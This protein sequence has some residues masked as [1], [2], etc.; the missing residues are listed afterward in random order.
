MVRYWVGSRVSGKPRL[1]LP[2]GIR[3]G[4][5][6]VGLVAGQPA[7]DAGRRP[8]AGRVGQCASLDKDPMERRAAQFGGGSRA[9]GPAISRGPSGVM[10]ESWQ[11]PCGTPS[12]G[13]WGRGNGAVGSGIC[14]WPNG[15]IRKS[16]QRPYG[17]RCGWFGGETRIRGPVQETVAG[18]AARFENFGNDPVGH[19]MTRFWRDREPG[20]RQRMFPRAGRPNS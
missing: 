6:Q 15:A 9:A 1:S 11:R 4:A 8:I 3:H 19:S 18:R 5:C 2:P 17:A 16:R 14:R 10:R 20:W 13:V 7:G 12:G